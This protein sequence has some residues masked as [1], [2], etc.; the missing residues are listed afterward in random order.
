[1]FPKLLGLIC[2]YKTQLNNDYIITN[3]FTYVIYD[4]WM[5]CVISLYDMMC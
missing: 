2:C 3:D 5:K 1:M 4:W